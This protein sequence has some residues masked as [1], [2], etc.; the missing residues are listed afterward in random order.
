MKAPLVFTINV[1]LS[2]TATSADECHDICADVKK[3]VGFKAGCSEFRNSLPR[4]M[5][6]SKCHTGFKAAV[7]RNCHDACVNGGR[8]QPFLVER[9]LDEACNGALKDAPRP[10]CHDAC[11]RG[12]RSGVKDM[13]TSLGKLMAEASPAVIT[14]LKGDTLSRQAAQKTH[15]VATDDSKTVEGTSEE[16]IAFAEDAIARPSQMADLSYHGKD[17]PIPEEK[18]HGETQVLESK[19]GL[20]TNAQAIGD[21][22]PLAAGDIYKVEDEPD[23]ARDADSALIAPDG[24]MDAQ[25]ELPE[26]KDGESKGEDNYMWIEHEEENV[27]LSLPITV[28]N[29]LKELVIFEGDQPLDVVLGFCRENMPEEGPAC[30]DE[31]IRVVQDKISTG[32]APEE[33]YI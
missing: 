1:I 13:T 11:V 33:E 10:L 30:A 12:Y 14:A 18:E 24:E 2:V 4:P 31:L 16:P 27:Q 3:R 21:E 28:D 6:S 22:P 32:K 26:I 5:V 17:T 8:L 23:L 29:V 15:V 25:H 19:G 7:E 9:R 20:Q